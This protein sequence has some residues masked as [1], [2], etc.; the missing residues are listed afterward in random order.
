MNIV[1]SEFVAFIGI[2]WAD[3]KHDL[4]LQVVETGA[5]ERSIL[6]HS[7]KAL[8]TWADELRTQL[9]EAKYPVAF[10]DRPALRPR[11]S[12]HKSN[13]CCAAPTVTGSKDAR[14]WRFSICRRNAQVARR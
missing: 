7:P 8:H 2:D 3:R 1:Q 5:R 10:D 4:C 11:S 13:R 9:C 14:P 6:E 12:S